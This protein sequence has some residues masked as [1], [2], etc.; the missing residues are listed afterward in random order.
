MVKKINGE[1]TIRTP[2]SPLTLEEDERQRIAGKR[3]RKILTKVTSNLLEVTEHP[4]IFLSGGAD[5]TTTLLAMIELGARPVCI[6]YSTD[7]RVS[8]DAKKARKLAEYYGLSFHIVQMPS[9]PDEVARGI[10]Q[11]LDKH[12]EIDPTKRPNIEVLYFFQEMFRIASTLGIKSVF[13]GI[14]DGSI[15]LVGRSG[16]IAGRLRGLSSTEVIAQQVWNLE[17]EQ[18]GPLTAIAAEFGINFCLP[19]TIT[20]AML[21]Y[22][23]LTWREMNIPRKKHITIR[24][25]QKE[26]DEIGL[27]VQPKP[28]QTGDSGARD[29]FD[30]AITQ[31]EYARNRAGRE[32][33]SAQ[34][35][36]NSIARSLGWEKERGSVGK[37]HNAWETWRYNVDGIEPTQQ[38][39]KPA[40]KITNGKAE[41]PVI[42][43]GDSDNLF[44]NVLAVSESKNMILDENG[45]PDTRV[46]C[47]G[48][49]FYTGEAKAKCR[50]A[51]AGLCGNYRPESPIVIEDC[52]HFEQWAEAGSLTL[53]SIA[54][55]I[56]ENVVRKVYKSWSKKVNKNAEKMTKSSRNLQQI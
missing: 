23:G 8:S 48:V 19:I 45:K 41:I 31:S 51:Q 27:I 16:E 21:P 14:G 25:F 55:E 43:T 9:D 24:A 47:F 1:L 10:D 33:I 46:D 49:P 37:K 26:L 13:S 29:Y 56:R 4:A 52:Y 5:S 30:N 38:G 40:Y 20:T 54:A 35:Y 39:Y 11:M 28:M 18:V 7:G 44:G 6:T 17:D 2:T 34:Q 50:R 3:F 15:H 32:V 22:A 12:K 42:F 53:D 36:Y